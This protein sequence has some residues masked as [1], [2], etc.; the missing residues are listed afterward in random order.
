MLFENSV[1]IQG[2]SQE[3]VATGNA[4]NLAPGVYDVW[5]AA[6]FYLRVAKSNAAATSG[7]SATT[8]YLVQAGNV[9]PVQIPA[10]AGDDGLWLGA[11]GTGSLNYHQV[12]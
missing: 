7:L 3:Q 9:V 4:V 12:A 8:G 1:N 10:S 5:A 2:R 6:D 11:F